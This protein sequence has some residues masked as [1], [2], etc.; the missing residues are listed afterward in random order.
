VVKFWTLYRVDP[1]ILEIITLTANSRIIHF[2]MR[3]PI[4]LSLFPLKMWHLLNMVFERFNSISWRWKS[5]T[6]Y[7]SIDVLG[8]QVR[9]GRPPFASKCF[10]HKQLSL[11]L[12]RLRGPTRS[13]AHLF[14]PHKHRFMIK[15][16]LTGTNLFYGQ[17]F[18]Q[19][20]MNAGKKITKDASNSRYVTWRSCVISSRISMLS[21]TMTVFG[22]PSSWSERR[23]RLNL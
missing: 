3:W 5:V 20:R 19:Y 2:C 12:A 17:V 4:V 6:T 13:I 1:I 16:D 23:P 22:R 10:F 15:R 8:C 21:G 7:I 14:R 18:M 9:A 11:D